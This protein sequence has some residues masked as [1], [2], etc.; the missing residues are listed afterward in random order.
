VSRAVRRVLI[1]A[2][3]L[4][5]GTGLAAAADSPS[6]GLPITDPGAI[7]A[8]MAGNTLSGVLKETG[9]TWVE[10]YCD[11]GRSLYQFGGINLGK[12]WTADGKVCFAYE[13]NDYRFPRCF[14]MFGKP[15][16]S[17]AF[18][19]HDDSGQAMTFLSSPPVP[20]DPFHLEERAVHGCAL[21][22]SV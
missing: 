18:L 15:D 13:Y 11:T 1:A 9:E 14:E 2:C 17:L 12:W 5:I 22:P 6:L 3:I 4:C 7:T 19:G 16:G 20:G 21:E 10:F 8:Q